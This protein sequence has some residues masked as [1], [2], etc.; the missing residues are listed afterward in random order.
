MKE[1]RLVAGTAANAL[2]LGVVY[3]LDLLVVIHAGRYNDPDAGW[4]PERLLLDHILPAVRRDR[5]DRTT[6]CRT[7]A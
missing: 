5:R 4:M 7:G 6:P 1:S 3:A 2:G